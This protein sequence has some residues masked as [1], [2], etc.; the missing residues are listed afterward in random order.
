MHRGLYRD[1]REFT[2]ESRVQSSHVIEVG[3]SQNSDQWYTE[4]EIC[5]SASVLSVQTVVRGC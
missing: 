5:I 1:F 3:A 4:A 2:T